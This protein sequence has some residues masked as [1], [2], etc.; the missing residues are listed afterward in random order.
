MQVSRKPFWHFPP[1]LILAGGDLAKVGGG[2]GL[3]NGDNCSH[4]AWVLN[5][6]HCS[7]HN[8]FLLFS[9]LAFFLSFCHAASVALDVDLSVYRTL[10]MPLATEVVWMFI[11]V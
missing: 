3:K 6:G 2:G 5:C 8:A 9:P 11:C 7:Q 10:T 1:V 4:A